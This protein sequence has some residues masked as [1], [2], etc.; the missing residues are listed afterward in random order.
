MVSEIIGFTDPF[1][2][3]NIP[4]SSKEENQSPQHISLQQ[5]AVIFAGICSNIECPI[6]QVPHVDFAVNKEGK[7][8]SEN[9]WLS[10][11]TKPATVIIPLETD[12]T[13]WIHVH[14]D[15]DTVT[16]KETVA[17][18]QLLFIDGSVVHSGDSYVLENESTPPLDLRPSLH[19]YLNSSLHECDLS[20]FS[21]CSKTAIDRVDVYGPIFKTYPALSKGVLHET[22]ELEKKIHKANVAGVLPQITKRQV[23]QRLRA[24]ADAIEEKKQE[25]SHNTRKRKR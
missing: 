2:P 3:K 22:E 7:S 6:P 21:T 17:K 11:L 5:G 4:S 9:E 20:L 15:G 1:Y 25:H 23:A 19:F 10:N 18:G 8:I 16:Y 13:L 12:R 14:V 24:M